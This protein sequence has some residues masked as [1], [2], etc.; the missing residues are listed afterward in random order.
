MDSNPAAKG[1]EEIFP[2][3]ETKIVVTTWHFR[4]GHV[5]N[6]TFRRTVGFPQHRFHIP[7][8]WKCTAQAKRSRSVCQ[9]LFVR[10]RDFCASDIDVSLEALRFSLRT[11]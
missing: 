4:S 8:I 6:S 7:W 10:N 5:R 2:V 3:M 11:F 9:A 1:T